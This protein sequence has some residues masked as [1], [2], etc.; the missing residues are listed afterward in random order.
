MRVPDD[1]N[2]VPASTR[3]HRAA[4]SGSARIL[5]T[6]S[7]ALVKG[8]LRPVHVQIVAS[9][10]AGSSMAIRAQPDPIYEVSVAT[11]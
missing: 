1:S 11:G 9:D 10:K 5:A 4:T 3:Q 8:Q 7:Q 2:H 6:T